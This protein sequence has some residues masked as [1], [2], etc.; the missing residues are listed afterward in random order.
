MI[1]HTIGD[2]IE[3][4]NAMAPRIGSF[5]VAT[6]PNREILIVAVLSVLLESAALLYSRN[7]LAYAHQGTQVQF[8]QAGDYLQIASALRQRYEQK[9]REWK[10]SQNMELAVANTGGFYSSFILTYR[11]LWGVNTLLDYQSPT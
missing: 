5:V 6:F 9:A 10:V 3:D 8:R 11:P 1:Y 4:F 2:M 7:D